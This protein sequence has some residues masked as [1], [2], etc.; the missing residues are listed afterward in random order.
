MAVASPRDIGTS[1]FREGC[2]IGNNP[3]YQRVIAMPGVSGYPDLGPQRRLPSSAGKPLRSFRM[4]KFFLLLFAALLV[5]PVVGA[6]DTFSSSDTV[7][8]QSSTISTTTQRRHHRK[9]RKHHHN[10]ANAQ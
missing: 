1:L 2:T 7:S 3:L 5:V 10:K 9:H 6:Q 8:A 4:K